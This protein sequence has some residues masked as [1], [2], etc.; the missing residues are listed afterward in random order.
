MKWLKDMDD[1]ALKLLLFDI[2][3]TLIR[4]AGAGRRSMERAFEQLYGI[5]NGFH[6]VEMMGRTDPAIV[7]EALENHRLEY[8][9]G[10]METY[11]RLYF[12]FLE[13][14]I[15]LPRDGKQVCVGIQKL[16]FALEQRS[17]LVL[18][19]LTGNWRTSGLI[20]IR[21][22]GL[23]KYFIFG[24]FADDSGIREEL[25]PIAIDRFKKQ[26]GFS[27]EPQ[28]VFVIGDTP[29]D[30]LCAKPHGVRSVAVAT[31]FHT[32]DE[33]AVEEPDFLFE[34]FEETEK[35]IEIFYS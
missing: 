22:F 2:D 4:S 1:G 20:K 19:L 18:G 9:D 24:G 28:N 7:K 25:V 29:L 21:H 3:G 8:Q 32:V 16:L 6:G 35:V 23:D 26:C 5:K 27:I 34:S 33:L 14:E 31:G 11:K 12:E 13:G 30:I 17:D 10:K 15:E